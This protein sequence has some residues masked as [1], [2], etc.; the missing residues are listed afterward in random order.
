MLIHAGIR[1]TQGSSRTSAFP[2]LDLRPSDQKQA[3]RLTQEGA[4]CELDSTVVEVP[5]GKREANLFQ[6]DRNERS[7]CR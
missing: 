1:W 4:C 6:N 3:W 7:A 5:L 2:L